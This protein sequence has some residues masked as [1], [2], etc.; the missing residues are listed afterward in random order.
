MDEQLA[1]LESA[2][3]LNTETVPHMDAV[4]T[5]GGAQS[6]WETESSKLE[7]D[8]EAELLATGVAAGHADPHCGQGTY[9]RRHGSWWCR[10]QRL[11]RHVPLKARSAQESKSPATLS[12]AS[13]VMSSAPS[14]VLSAE[15]KA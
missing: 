10:I 14:A 1:L 8:V 6:A 7:P 13:P 12:A 3:S 5:T 15:A 11:R 4:A 2:T 9:R